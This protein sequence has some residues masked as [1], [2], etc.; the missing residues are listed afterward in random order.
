MNSGSHCIL[1]KTWDNLPSTTRF[2]R[3]LHTSNNLCRRHQ[4]LKSL[5]TRGATGSSL[6]L[7]AMDAIGSTPLVKLSNLGHHLDLPPHTAIYGKLSCSFVEAVL[8]QGVMEM[9][10]PLILQ[11]RE[12]SSI[13]HLRCLPGLP[14]SVADFQSPLA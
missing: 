7:S 11:H 10:A 1:P 4:N 6:C 2:A 13:I 5:H 8:A 3:L 14:S 12:L 9:H